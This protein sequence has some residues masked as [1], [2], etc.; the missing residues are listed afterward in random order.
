MLLRNLYAEGPQRI[1]ATG[2]AIGVV[3]MAV[4]STSSTAFLGLALLG[5]IYPINWV[6]RAVFS[7][8]L[9]QS[10]LIGELL[11]GLGLLAALLFILIARADLFNPLVGIVQEVILNKP[12]TDSYY[13]RSE[14]SSVAWQTVPSTWGLGVGFG[15]TRTSSWFAAIV[16]NAGLIGATCIAI[17]LVQTFAR[18]PSSRSA[19]SVELSWGLKLSLLPALAMVGVNSAGPDF[20]LWMAVVLGAV[21][22]VAKSNPQRGSSL[23]T[24]LINRPIARRPQFVSGHTRSARL[25][26]W[27]QRTGAVA[28]KRGP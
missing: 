27:R 19:F 18:R 21:A 23:D 12:L 8:E 28:P 13:Q 16:S 15:S 20:G 22:G 11:V 14:W 6:R 10:G 4:L 2:V 9:G 17:F 24:S 25:P 5:M 7:P 3:V 26:Y 1:L